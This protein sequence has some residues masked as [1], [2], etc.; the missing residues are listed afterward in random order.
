MKQK[1]FFIS[2]IHSI[3][4]R[5]FLIWFEKMIEHSRQSAKYGKLNEC[6]SAICLSEATV[7]NGW[8]FIVIVMYVIFRALLFG[9]IIF[10]NGH[11][12]Q[13]RVLNTIINK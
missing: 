5:I 11:G 1:F 6:E 12:N 2:P 13:F 8:L 4:V 3:Y 9:Y 7:Q 10:F